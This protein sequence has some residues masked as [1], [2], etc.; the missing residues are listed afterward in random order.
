MLL[1][2][3]LKAKL[4]KFLRQTV[5]SFEETTTLIFTQACEMQKIVFI[6]AAGPLVHVMATVQ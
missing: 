5:F 3:R 6:A 4:K 2:R 1:Y